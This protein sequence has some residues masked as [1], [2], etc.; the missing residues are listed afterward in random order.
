MVCI[1]NECYEKDSIFVYIV[2][3]S[4]IYTMLEKKDGDVS[5]DT[6]IPRG[7]QSI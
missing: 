7:W 5:N 2:R 4:I 6:Y 1:N 3:E